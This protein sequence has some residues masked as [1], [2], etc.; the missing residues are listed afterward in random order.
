MTDI[1]LSQNQAATGNSTNL[2]N[3][4]LVTNFNV[5][6]YYDDYD[7]NKQYYR[8]LFKP[9]YAVQARELTQMQSMLQSQIYRFGSNIF[10]EGSIVLPWCNHY[11][12][13]NERH[14]R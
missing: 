11:S 9:G 3:T 2:A 6:P 8:I 14:T 7:P 13:S 1:V 12:H 5:N 4:S 10:K